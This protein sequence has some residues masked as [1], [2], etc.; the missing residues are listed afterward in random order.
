MTEKTENRLSNPWAFDNADEQMFSPNKQNRIE[1]GELIELAM[2][3]PL[4]GE[5]YWCD[6]DN[7]KYKLSG[8]YGG[9]PVWN[10]KGNMVA[11]PIWSRTI[12]KGTIQQLSI[13]DVIKSEWTLYKRTFRVLDLRRFQNEIVSGYDSPI[14]DTTPLHF[15]LSREQIEKRKKI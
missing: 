4:A 14:C 13:I 6:S 8:L 5:C 3:S 9:P 2:G 7:R 11:I 10:S 1:Y 15:E 12:F